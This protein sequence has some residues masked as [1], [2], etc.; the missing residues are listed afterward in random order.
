MREMASKRTRAVTIQYLDENSSVVDSLTTSDPDE[1]TEFFRHLAEHIV[2]WDG[3]E[4]D[5]SDEFTTGTIE[6][7]AQDEN[8]YT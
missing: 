6:W 4:N 1:A 3:R 2:I 8:D 7:W 5:G